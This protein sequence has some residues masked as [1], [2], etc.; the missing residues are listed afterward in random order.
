[1]N[2][3]V[4]AEVVDAGEGAEGGGEGADVCAAVGDVVATGEGG[5]AD[6]GDGGAV[7]AEVGVAAD[8]E[9]DLSRFVCFFVLSFTVVFASLFFIFSFAGSH[10]DSGPLAPALAL[11]SLRFAHRSS[12]LSS[13]LFFPLCLS[14]LLAVVHAGR[15]ERSAVNTATS[16]SPPGIQM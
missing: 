3:V 15:V 1:M 14:L 12:F 4:G 5:G 16:H 11:L 13:S 9:A 8:G 2:R 7:T 6:D 10:F